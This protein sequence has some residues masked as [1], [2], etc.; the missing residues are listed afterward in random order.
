[1]YAIC[2]IGSNSIKT[3]FFKEESG[4]YVHADSVSR[5]A[6]LISYIEDGVMNT[7]G[8]DLLCDVVREYKERADAGGYAFHAFATASLRRADNADEIISRVMECTGVKIDLVS[9]EKEAELC[10]AG[11]IHE[12]GDGVNGILMDMGG[13][14]TEIIGISASRAVSAYS[15]PFG[16]LSLYRE[17]VTGDLPDADERGRIAA[18]VF[19]CYREGGAP[20]ADTL[21]I[22]GGTGKAILKFMGKKGLCTVEN[23]ELLNL[24]ESIIA[25]EI[26]FESIRELFPDRAHAITPGLIAICEILRLSGAQRATFVTAGARE[27]Y[28]L[29]IL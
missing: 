29:S 5:T 24:K 26:S 20:T 8:I 3:H 12:I 2:D 27:G 22:G 14:S 10:T 4:T 11:V 19:D 28:L 23:A 18:Y 9:G 1:M 15:M 6:R 17:N 21:Y 7:A 25:G 16:S 13:G